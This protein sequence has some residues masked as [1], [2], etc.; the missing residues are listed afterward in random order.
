MV[1]KTEGKVT[2]GR[3]NSRWDDTVNMDK[4]IRWK[5]MD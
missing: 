3:P 5:G 4:G 1:G 2:L